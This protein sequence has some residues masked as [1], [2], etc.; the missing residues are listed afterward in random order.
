MIPDPRSR[1][2]PPR[3][4][5]ITG[6]GPITPAGVGVDGLWEGLR[7]LE[8][9]VREVTRFDVSDFRTRIAA[10]L[11]DFDPQDFLD[12]KQIRRLDLFAQLTLAST[13]MALRDA[14][15]EPDAVDPA[16]TAVQM[17]SAIGGLAHAQQQLINFVHE[18]LRAVD[19]RV[20]TTVFAGAAS[21]H[22]AIEFGFTG[23]N[24]TNAM[25]CASGAMAVGDAFRLIRDGVSDVA[26]A[27]GV[28]APLGPLSFGA[29][30]VIRAMSQRND[31]PGSACRPFD[32]DRDGFVMGE[33]ACIMVLEAEE[34]ARARGAR[35][36]AEVKGYGV[37]ND[38][39]H[40][41]A[42]RPDGSQAAE[43]M[44]QAISSAG[45]QPA[46][47]DHVNAHASS[48]PLND[49]TESLAIRGV[50]G[51]HADSVTVTGTKPYYGHALG[52]SGAIELAIV[53][54]SI[55]R[56]WIPPTLNL[57]AA[58]E[59]CDLPYV[60]GPGAQQ[61]VG[62]ALSNSFGFGGINAALVLAA[63]RDPGRETAS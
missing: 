33:G 5:V 62:I 27:G 28:E 36:Y 38:A 63:P 9:P 44:R 26:V 29:F 19:P 22:T 32:K 31:D 34:H 52:A 55:Q 13:R 23:P 46:D 39:Y 24:S 58:G 12:A 54:L 61:E 21:C 41:A 1:L 59:G 17:G 30:V 48:T 35:V 56:G 43:A 42:P 3:R 4:V 18:G 47:V 51:D 8:S 16:R 60:T 15:I 6:L 25:S 53:C 37:T 7:R 57:H 20:S 50:L 10:E 40:M 11:T 49:S 2:D 45:I 14:G